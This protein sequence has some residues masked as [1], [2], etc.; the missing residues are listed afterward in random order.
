[1]AADGWRPF[2]DGI[3]Q[4]GAQFGCGS[5]SCFKYYIKVTKPCPVGVYVEGAVMQKGISFGR[6]STW[7]SALQSGDAALVN[8]AD[9]PSSGSD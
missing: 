4:S 8:L 2:V 3:Y 1:M 9:D 6:T 7:T 5:L